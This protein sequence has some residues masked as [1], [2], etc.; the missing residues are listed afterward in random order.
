MNPLVIL[1]NPFKTGE[2]T[3]TAELLG[4]FDETNTIVVNNN[5]VKTGNVFKALAGT[6]WN[7]KGQRFTNP[8]DIEIPIPLCATGFVREDRM[9]LNMSN[10]FV[11]VLGQEVIENPVPPAKPADTLDY[12]FIPVNDIEVSVPTP[13]TTGRDFLKKQFD[14][15]Q[16]F[17][18]AGTNVVIPLNTSGAANIYISGPMTSL[19]GFSLAAF[20]VLRGG[21]YPHEGKRYTIFNISGHDIVLKHSISANNMFFYFK[22]TVDLVIPNNGNIEFI[23]SNN[24]LFE[25]DK[26]WNTGGGNLTLQQVTDNGNSTTSSMA[27]VD[28]VLRTFGV[29]NSNEQTKAILLNTGVLLLGNTNGDVKLASTN[30]TQDRVL[31][32]PDEN[33][34][35]ST[36]QYVNT[37]F[38]SFSASVPNL[39]QVTNIGSTVTD[40]TL[41]F[42][43]NSE[44]DDFSMLRHK[45]LGF[46][47]SNRMCVI[48]KNGL[49]GKV[50]Y[51]QYTRVTFD[52]ATAE[53]S[54]VFPAANGKIAVVG[55]T[56]PASATAT[57]VVGEIRVTPTFIYTCIATN[58]WVRV[59]MA[60]W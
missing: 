31:E 22:D 19:S 51:G 13:V 34:I 7:L 30:I 37:L 12:T 59:A 42:T 53:K 26:S 9:V 41:S 60:T 23:T 48:D 29:L 27:I 56:A 47:S 46:F 18:G 43:S 24:I 57:G 36:Q 17:K 45:D 28:T 1:K 33:G 20:Q 16:R 6:V 50:N 44:V 11:L 39:N 15:K 8:A 2:L 25:V 58:T 55:T 49:I 14:L 4:S 38:S 32:L 5:F 35:L 21:E 10:N 40:K 54:I 52:E 3:T